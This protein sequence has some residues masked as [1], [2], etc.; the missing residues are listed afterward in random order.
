VVAHS[1]TNSPDS[2]T[3]TGRGLFISG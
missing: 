2:T 1:G 3:L